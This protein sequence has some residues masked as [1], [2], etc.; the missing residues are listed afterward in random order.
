MRTQYT[1]TVRI[2]AI[3]SQHLRD[4]TCRACAVRSEGGGVEGAAR[5]TSGAR[6]EGGGDGGAGG[7]GG[8]GGEGSGVEGGRRG[9]LLNGA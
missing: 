6:G 1:G 4:G 5:A 8:G 9:L 7:E 2:C 3:D